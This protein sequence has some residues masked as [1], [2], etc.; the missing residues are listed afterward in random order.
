[1]KWNL[2]ESFYYFIHIF[3]NLLYIGHSKNHIS[4][5]Q[6]I[7]C[8]T[9]ASNSFIRENKMYSLINRTDSTLDCC[10]TARQNIIEIKLDTSCRVL[11]RSSRYNCMDL[12]ILINAVFATY[13]AWLPRSVL[14]F[15]LPSRAV[16]KN[17][18]LHSLMYNVKLILLQISILVH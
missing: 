13:L 3:N 10:S 11:V 8:L 12:I 14:G 1:M 16:T 18:R 5:I 2:R 6:Q 15:N 9:T 17:D 7:S 4:N